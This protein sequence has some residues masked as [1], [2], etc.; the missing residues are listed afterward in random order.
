MK[1]LMKYKALLAS[2]ALAF[3]MMMSGMTAEAMTV[4]RKKVDD[5][6]HQS[7]VGGTVTVIGD[8][9]KINGKSVSKMKK[10]VHANCTS[11]DEYYDSYYKSKF[12]KDSDA[13]AEGVSISDVLAYTGKYNYVFTFQKTGTYKFTT[14]DYSNTF[15]GSHYYKME[16]SRSESINGVRTYY[17][18]LM[19]ITEDETGN[20]SYV[21]VPGEE[22]VETKLVREFDGYSESETYY[23]GTVSGKMY[24]FYSGCG[25]CP[26]TIKKGAD[27]K[28]YLYIEP[29]IVKT[30]ETQTVKVFKTNKVISSVQLGSA[31]QVFTEKRTSTSTSDTSTYKRFLTGKNGK[32]KVKMADKNYAIQSI[33]LITYDAQG[34]A[35]YQIVGNNKKVTFGA[36]KSM[37]TRQR[38]NDNY[39][40]KSTSLYKPT[41]VYVYYKN[42]YTGA[43]CKINKIYKDAEGNYLFD[44]TYQNYGDEKATVVTGATSYPTRCYSSYIFYKK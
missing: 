6:K 37:Y 29:I 35:Q 5:A 33:M 44:Y 7:Y 42:K 39:S 22:Y 43:F 17:Y 28:D 19:Q 21:E 2:L 15:D 3:L 23:V 20:K 10:K 11:W 1:S 14:V 18:K 13:Y 32:L 27:G 34:K 24:A 16:L 26:A 40:Y 31:K 25:Y 38:P 30:T 36:N 12:F 8:N 41:H 9:V 4:N